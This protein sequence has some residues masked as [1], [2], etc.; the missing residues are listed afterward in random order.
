MMGSSR[1]GP[2]RVQGC[3]RPPPIARQQRHVFACQFIHDFLF[4]A[5]L[6]FFLDDLVRFFG[7]T[8]FGL[9]FI[10]EVLGEVPR[11]CRGHG[12]VRLRADFV[13]L[14]VG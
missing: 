5:T 11:L 2:V 3:G 9:S 8:V 1:W 13:P 7:P 14:L 10:E 6:E 4:R 12:A